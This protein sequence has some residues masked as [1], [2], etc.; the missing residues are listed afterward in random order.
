MPKHTD[1]YARAYEACAEIFTELARFPTIDLVR[2]RIGVN[3]PTVIKRAI[4][5]WTLAFA[6][7]ARA[8]RGRPDLPGALLDAADTLWQLALREAHTQF[9]QDRRAWVGEKTE[10]E[11]RLSAAEHDREALAQELEAH[12]AA[13]TAELEKHTEAMG[14]LHQQLEV[15]QAGRTAAEQALAEVRAELGILAATLATERAQFAQRH[16]D[17]EARIE[18]AQRWHLQRIAEEKTRLETQR[19]RELAQRDSELSRLTLAR[20]TLETRLR[21][22]QEQNAE[23]RGRLAALEEQLT[24]AREDLADQDR[25]VTTLQAQVAALTAAASRAH[26]ARKPRPETTKPRSP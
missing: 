26:K 12:R 13:V 24:T 16:H 8:K 25:T 17:W 10:L 11:D 6:E 15:E 18:D 1:T 21:A 20:E 2:E 23:G 14:Q 7:Q 4:T 19:Q 22:V 9:E 3:S 5:D